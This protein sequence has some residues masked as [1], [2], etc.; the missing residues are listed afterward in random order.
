MSRWLLGSGLLALVFFASVPTAEAAIILWGQGDSITKI[1][2]TSPETK[3]R[4]VMMSRIIRARSGKV[5]PTDYKIGYKYSYFSLFFMNMW[6]WK[7]SFVLYRKRRY[8]SLTPKRAK[9]YKI[10]LSSLSKPFGY[11]YPLG[12]LVLIGGGAF[13][14]VLGGMGGSEDEGTDGEAADKLL[15][16]SRGE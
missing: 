13:L 2:E 14:L 10:K 1:K 9:I 12:L 4:L 7:G 5:I 3:K 15:Q 8:I 16:N 11:R 6:T